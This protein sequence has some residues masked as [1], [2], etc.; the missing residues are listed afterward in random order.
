M[1]PFS[2]GPL[3]ALLQPG[4]SV[5]TGRRFE[6]PADDHDIGLI[7]DRSTVLQ[8]CVIIGECG[9]FHKGTIVRID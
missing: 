1:I 5:T 4:E 2:E 9:A 3:N 8:I 6:L 7:V